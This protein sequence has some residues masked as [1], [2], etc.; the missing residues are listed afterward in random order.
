[1]IDKEFGN[2]VSVAD[3]EVKAYYDKYPSFFKKPEQVRARHILIKVDPKADSKEKAEAHK[4]IEDIQHKLQKGED[5][6]ALAKEFSQCPSAAN[7]G[8]LGS[9]GRGQMVKPFEEAAFALKPG[10]VSDI[11]ETRF[12]YHLIEVMDKKPAT[13]IPYKDIKDRLKQYL[14]QEK[15]QKEVRLYAEKLKEKAKVE[16]F[17]TESQ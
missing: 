2:T 11:V 8:D 15:I 6:E 10:E 4:K 9:F 5:F 16:R 1:L 14:K 17:L 7:G 3:K 12:G 13:T